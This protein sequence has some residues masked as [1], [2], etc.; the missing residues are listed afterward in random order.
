MRNVP[1]LER[2]EQVA[3]FVPASDLALGAVGEAL[4]FGERAL[5]RFAPDAPGGPAPDPTPA[6]GRYEGVVRVDFGPIARFSDLTGLEDAAREIDGADVVVE[7]VSGD[8]A[9]LALRLRQPVELL[10]ELALRSAQAFHVRMQ[11]GNR[12]VLDLEQAETGTAAAA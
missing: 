3:R 5:A 7:R 2:L 11:A 9:I 10:A 1:T 6:D 8:R 12:L 4:R